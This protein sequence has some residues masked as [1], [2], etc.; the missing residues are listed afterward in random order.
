MRGNDKQSVTK[1]HGAEADQWQTESGCVNLLRQLKKL[2]A[3]PRVGNDK[4]S[5]RVQVLILEGSGLK[6]RHEVLN[7][8]SVILYATPHDL[9]L[10]YRPRK[11]DSLEVYDMGQRASV[12]IYIVD[13][14]EFRRQLLLPRKISPKVTASSFSCHISRF[15]AIQLDV[16]F[17]DPK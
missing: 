8:C 13:R 11:P 15:I 1:I 3:L 7:D 6:N 16:V 14:V 12:L 9:A 17:D 5:K 4:S 2:E 10:T